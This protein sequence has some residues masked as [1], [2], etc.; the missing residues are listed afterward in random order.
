MSEEAR[1]I[2]NGGLTVAHKESKEASLAV[3]LV[4]VGD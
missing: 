4:K 1:M 3:D 2:V